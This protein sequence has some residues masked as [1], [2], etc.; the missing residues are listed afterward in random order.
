M[1]KNYPDL[2]KIEGEISQLTESLKQSLT[3][4]NRPQWTQSAL[5]RGLNQ[6][7]HKIV[8]THLTNGSFIS[9]STL[10]PV[11]RQALFKSISSYTQQKT[12]E[13]LQKLKPVIKNPV[14]DNKDINN[15]ILTAK[16]M[17]A[18]WL[19]SLHLYQMQLQKTVKKRKR[20]AAIKER[21]K[22]DVL[23][24]LA[25]QKITPMPAPDTVLI[26]P[27][28]YLTPIPICR[29]DYELPKHLHILGLK[30][31]AGHHEIEAAF[32]KLKE[33]FLS[34]ENP[35]HEEKDQFS[36]ASQA[37]QALI[38]VDN[39]RLTQLNVIKESEIRELA[40]NLKGEMPGILSNG[41]S[42]QEIRTG[43]IE[44][45]LQKNLDD[46]S[47]T[48]NHQMQKM[49]LTLEKLENQFGNDPEQSIDLS[50]FLTPEQ[51]PSSR[52]GQTPKLTMNR[53]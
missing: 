41:A 14:D 31:G 24:Q 32:L 6:A 10:P 40:D 13:I 50:K 35:T 11:E 29:Y 5:T 22:E 9:C 12:V 45:C 20:L 43:I 16:K 18:A 53:V 33:E 47:P 38:N 25:E 8:A 26:P 36:L 42:L 15:K 3:A 7:I 49:M 28:V 46:S 2:T 37:H 21:E 4:S 48:S 23:D 39:S 30:L 51:E 17:F 1:K 27:K 44:S 34:K 19:E 52:L